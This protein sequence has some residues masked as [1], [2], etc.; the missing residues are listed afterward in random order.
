MNTNKYLF[1]FEINILTKKKKHFFI[2]LYIKILKNI[3][4]LTYCFIML[5]M[6]RKNNRTGPR[7][8]W[9]TLGPC[10]FIKK[11]LPLYNCISL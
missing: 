1:F 10:A 8:F 4:I 7:T 6:Y 2:K 3:I 11:L 9:S 5:F